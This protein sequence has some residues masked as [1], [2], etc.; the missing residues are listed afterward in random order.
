[1]Q[2][3]LYKKTSTGAVQVWWMEV[4]G[5][6]YRTHSGKHNGKI[7]TSEWTLAKPKNVGRAN[8][9]T[10]EEQAVAEVESQYTKKAKSGYVSSPEEA[11]ASTKFKPMLAKNYE[12]YA[13]KHVWRHGMVW[14]QPKLDGVRCIATKDGLFSRTWHRI[15][16][17]PHIEIGLRSFFEKNPD[18]ILDGEL[19]NHK[20]RD[21]FNR[22]VSL[23]RKTKPSTED[24]IES[25]ENIEYWMFDVAG[26]KADLPFSDRVQ[27]L[28]E[29]M[30]AYVSTGL[31]PFR[32]TPS[33]RVDS[34]E[35][36]D[37]YYQQFLDSGFEGQMIRVPSVYEQ[38]RSKF[39]L[40][41]KEF[42]DSEFTVVE[43]EEGQGNSSGGAR[44]AHL[45]LDTNPEVTF[46]ADVT[47]ST[48]HR[49]KILQEKAKY[50]G[51]QATVK[52]FSQRTPDGV[53][54]FG[55]VISFY[56]GKRSL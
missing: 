20:L 4:S 24:F 6:K 23:V 14:T 36:L 47:G 29:F 55:K 52:Y 42:V 25:R 48:E 45:R 33:H 50:I 32:I 51:G 13:D 27:V 21:D 40:K 10:A 56:E 2:E 1:M 22:I 5:P 11:L 37:V 19:Y 46:K 8:A 7:V 30:E 15:L 18:T 34:L 53:P 31:D 38:K 9:T 17:V 39:L 26:D 41:R 35:L 49:A 44:I 3:K 54:R 12:D 43:I 16:A 28:E